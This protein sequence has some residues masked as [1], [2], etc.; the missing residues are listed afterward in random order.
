MDRLT[1]W[2]VMCILVGCG[3][4]A[5]ALQIYLRRKRFLAGAE[6]AEGS[7][8]EVRVQGIGRNA[9]SLPVFDFRTAAGEV[10][11][12]ESLM[13]SGFQGFEVG[14]TIA[15]KYDP[16]NPSRAEVDSFA[17]LWGLALLRAGF[18]LLFLLM[19]SIGLL[20]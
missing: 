2:G 9:V 3:F 19:G 7:V 16:S 20:L 11:R 5:S 15:V 8:V 6:A 17:V 14:E 1:V 4:L 13:G 10:Q 12:A 18:A